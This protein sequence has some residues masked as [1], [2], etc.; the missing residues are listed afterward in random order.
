MYVA[1]RPDEDLQPKKPGT[2]RFVCM[3]DT[4]SKIDF[5]FVIP[6]GD[7][8]V[9]AGDLT[10]RSSIQEFKET[11]AWLGALPHRLK[12]VTGGNHDHILDERFG[13]IEEKQ[14]VLSRMQQANITYLE[15]ESYLLPPDLGGYKMF[16]SPYAPIHLG[17]A[18][19]P[20]NLQPYWEKI[21]SDTQVL[22]T[23]TPPYG[24][25]DRIIRGN[26]H[27]GCPHLRAKIDQIR[28][29]VSIFGH[30]H[31]SHGV[32]FSEHTLFV[33]ASACNARYRANQPPIVFDL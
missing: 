25:Q 24:Y 14:Y 28:P 13:Y 17:G 9:H 21:P 27:V 19:M 18:F 29:K 3:S 31:E 10:R 5:Q 16:V 7:V 26:R 23:H 2:T 15:H 1:A 32:A 20:R 6:D 30:I 12:I 8:F 11:I 33:N 4:H 22:V